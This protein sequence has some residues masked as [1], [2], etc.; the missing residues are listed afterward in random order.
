[1]KKKSLFMFAV[2]AIVL[3][4]II[5][6]TSCGNKGNNNDAGNKINLEGSG[7]LANPYKIGT[8]SNLDVITKNTKTDT[9]GKYFQL[10][11]DIADYETSI[12]TNNTIFKGVLDGNGK[13]ITFEGDTGLFSSNTGTIS[14][15]TVTGA[16][17]T[18]GN[19]IVGM[20]ANENAG[21]VN[22]VTATG[23]VIS[24]RG[25]IN[26]LADVATKGAGA[27]VGKNSAN[28]VI[29]NATNEATVK[30]TVGGAGIASVNYGT[31]EQSHNGAAIGMEDKTETVGNAQYSYMG[32]ISSVNYGT[33]KGSSS[34]AYVFA[35]ALAEANPNVGN[36]YVGG[37]AGY[38][39]E[40]AIITE[41]SNTYGSAVATCGDKY[42][43]GIVGY[44]DG[45]VSYS[46]CNSPIGARSYYGAIAGHVGETG[47]VKGCFGNANGNL[48]GLTHATVEEAEAAHFYAIANKATNCVYNAASGARGQ[49][50]VGENNLAG[51]ANN[52]N[53]ELT[54][55]AL[56]ALNAGLATG[57]SKMVE[58]VS[59][60]NANPKLYPVA[61]V[62]TAT[63]KT[64]ATDE[65]PTVLNVGK[66]ASNATITLP[67]V[68]T[69]TGF[70]FAGWVTNLEDAANTLVWNAE[71][72]TAELTE[73]IVVYAYF[74]AVTE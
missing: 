13:V 63:F 25:T 68:E 56:A 15:L 5:F 59:P 27:L 32:G 46:I 37:I 41:S 44:T 52:P 31:I 28:A 50:P 58:V 65:A 22:N 57:Q 2:G 4:S 60:S 70:V 11:A 64:S 49:A 21:T 73:N 34:K 62:K 30:A 45:E 42:V 9:T 48:T 43:G 3:P 47:T 14:N 36:S 74:T 33:I 35:P 20:L 53:A 7:T 24:T 16:L 8:A 19:G 10:T 71:T 54:A 51:I 72:T 29:K 55:S 12:A 39:A 61:L 66:F 6:L 23:S 38:N 17:T 26:T 18:T 69:A 67:T 1:M 40:N